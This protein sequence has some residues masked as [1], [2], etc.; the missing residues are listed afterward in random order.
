MRSAIGDQ[1]AEG[2]LIEAQTK[3]VDR[4]KLLETDQKPSESLFSLFQIPPDSV[5]TTSKL[6]DLQRIVEI[7]RSVIGKENQSDK[8]GANERLAQFVMLNPHELDYSQN[9][10]M[11]LQQTDEEDPLRD[12]LL[13]A[14]AKLTEDESLRIQKLVKLQE[15]YPKTDGG[16]QAMYELCFLSFTRWQKQDESDAELKKEY[17][18][19]ARRTLSNFIDLYPKSF[20]IEQVKKYLDD[21]PAN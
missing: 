15:Q 19:G 20:Y 3:I 5:M 1:P 17:M 13:L 6:K 8:P 12:N 7:T 14:Q 4:L 2:I 11:L 21:I 16:M 18:E 10:S 9:I